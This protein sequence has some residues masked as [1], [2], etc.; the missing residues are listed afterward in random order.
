MAQIKLS[1]AIR[2][3][4]LHKLKGIEVREVAIFRENPLLEPDWVWA[5]LKQVWAVV[6]LK[7]Q[8]IRFFGQL[9]HLIRC[10]TCIG[11]DGGPLP[12]AAEAVAHRIGGIVESGEHGEREI[13]QVVGL[14]WSYPYLLEKTFG[15]PL[16]NVQVFGGEHRYPKLVGK[17]LDPC[18]MV[19]VHMG[20]KDEFYILDIEAE[21]LCP[22][23]EF[24]AGIAVIH[25][26]A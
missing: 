15:D 26:E 20:K 14:P 12:S 4:A 19:A 11:D 5:L 3:K 7:E 25:N 1:K 16:G 17:G 2:L 13:I 6:G 24:G 21:S 10:L 22:A 9:F 23:A 18:Y 8:D